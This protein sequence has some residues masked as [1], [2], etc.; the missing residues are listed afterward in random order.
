MKDKNSFY[1]KVHRLGRG[2]VLLVLTC[3]ISIPF[4]LGLFNGISFDIV[5]AL[6]NGIPILLTFTIAG[7]C[8]NLSF[9]PIIGC[10][11]LYMACVTGNVNNMKAPA[12]INAME[13]SGHAPGTPKGDVIAILAVAASTCVTTVIVFAG[14]LFLAPLFAPIYN[15]TFLQPAFK[16]LV[17]ALYGALLFPQ[18]AKAPKQAAIAVILPILIRFVVGAEF[19]SANSSYI[20]IGVI[21]VSTLF[22]YF[23]YKRDMI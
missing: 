8:E 21:I 6:K 3:M 4:L 19:F 22:S 9:A 11:A 2:T 14:M 15:N 5:S 13:V 10:G 18:I 17:P 23:L 7:V 12:A 20:M 16:N 1:N